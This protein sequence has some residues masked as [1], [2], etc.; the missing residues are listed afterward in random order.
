[1]ALTEQRNLKST[2]ILHESNI[3]QVQWADQVLRDGT[4]ISENFHRRAY[5]EAEYAQYL[6]DGG[7]QAILDTAQRDTLQMEKLMLRDECAQK[8]AQL[9][10]L[11]QAFSEL[12]AA[13]AQLESDMAAA[14]QAADAKSAAYEAKIAELQAQLAQELPNE[15]ALA[16]GA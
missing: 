6:A 5:S 9:T 11:T 3:V 10:Q 14:Q 1:M 13:K 16:E 15:T 4:V 8:D 12:S 7:T 2:T